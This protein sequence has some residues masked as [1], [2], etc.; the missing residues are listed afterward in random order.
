MLITSHIQL[1]SARSQDLSRTRSNSGKTS[2]P[3]E[4]YVSQAENE[5]RPGLLKRMGRG[6]K[7][8]ASRVVKLGQTID[9]VTTRAAFA[10]VPGLAGLGLQ[11]LSDLVDKVPGQRADRV[12]SKLESLA[13]RSKRMALGQVTELGSGIIETKFGPNISQLKGFERTLAE[14][15]KPRDGQ[16]PDYLE[17]LR[18]GQLREEKSDTLS[19]FSRFPAFVH[20]EGRPEA[21][22]ELAREFHHAETSAEVN[23]YLGTE[24]EHAWETLTR[25]RNTGQLPVFVDLD[26][27]P[28]EVSPTEKIAAGMVASLNDRG[29]SGDEFSS[30]PIFLEST[31]LR[32]EA[33]QKLDGW[34]KTNQP[35]I[36][37]TVDNV[38]K[39]IQPM[40]T[41][42]IEKGL[43]LVGAATGASAPKGL[44]W[45]SDPSKLDTAYN[46]L[47]LP[48]AQAA[49]SGRLEDQ[50]RWVDTVSSLDRDLFTGLQT[51]W[52]RL[53]K[54]S[55]PE[56][57]QSLFRPLV[58][59]WLD[60]SLSEDQAS[61]ALI[62]DGTLDLPYNK[63]H[64]PLQSIET[65]PYN[66]GMAAGLAIDHL[67]DGAGIDERKQMISFI[68]SEIRNRDDK[69]QSF[70]DKNK[71]LGGVRTLPTPVQILDKDRNAET[72]GSGLEAYKALQ[73]W[74]DESSERY[75]D[76]SELLSPEL[77][78]V[79]EFYSPDQK[80]PE[81][82]DKVMKLMEAQPPG[83]T[84]LTETFGQGEK[85]TK[86]SLVFAGGGGKGMVYT[87]L[88]Y[89]S[90]SPRDS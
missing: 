4:S 9:K 35:Q 1:A 62:P 27:N 8:A 42:L 24:L 31:R 53:M 88:L 23:P 25:S 13:A 57:R 54:E 80:V 45:R 46:S 7:K 58:T 22:R 49:E 15:L 32:L 81:S 72:D 69:A 40:E 76:P 64:T 29:A 68:H 12:S 41:G 37:H 38:K 71:T 66:R 75:F 55:T 90:P 30:T 10:A 16:L 5:P 67:L 78:G 73:T 82:V 21:S 77:S 63:T 70:V 65:Q 60:L 19:P 51:D 18:S 74:I 6:V 59:S 50:A 86:S 36:W 56:Q 28:G 14:E 26:G 89:T 20:L 3:K 83:G 48:L 43:G 39:L 61:A 2:E 85:T 84:P 17:E 11:G 52:M 34:M 79:S 33:H 87:C 47:L 44:Q